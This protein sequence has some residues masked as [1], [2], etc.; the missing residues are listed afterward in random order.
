MK[1]TDGR[2]CFFHPKNG[3]LSSNSLSRALS[4]RESL[5]HWWDGLPKQS[6]FFI[7]SQ[8]CAKEEVMI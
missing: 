7:L 4:L 6:I 8:S 2:A 5:S 3:T 1:C